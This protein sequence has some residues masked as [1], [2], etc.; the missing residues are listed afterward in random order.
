LSGIASEA[1]LGIVNALS[2]QKLRRAKKIPVSLSECKQ[3]SSCGEILRG[4]SLSSMSMPRGSL[5]FGKGNLGKKHDQD[6]CFRKDSLEMTKQRCF[7]PSEQT[8]QNSRPEY[9]NRR[10][11]GEQVWVSW[12]NTGAP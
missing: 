6:H 10:R 9:E 12:T 2:F 11:K 5:V 4:G 8:Q 1:A 3:A 7:S